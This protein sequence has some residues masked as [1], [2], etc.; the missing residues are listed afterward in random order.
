MNASDE[1][2]VELLRSHAQQLGEH[3]DSVQIFANRC[4]NGSDNGT[5]AVSVGTGNMFARFGQVKLW[6][7]EQEED[8]R[9]EMR[10]HRAGEDEE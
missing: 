4:E 1:K 5:Q 2:D 6:V 10:D 8:A 7:E 9:E 3:F